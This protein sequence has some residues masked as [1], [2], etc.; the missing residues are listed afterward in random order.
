MPMRVHIDVNEFR[1]VC[2]NPLDEFPRYIIALQVGNGA[3][4]I[5]KLHPSD[6]YKLIEQLQRAVKATKLR[7]RL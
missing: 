2:P 1:V 3:D 6:I 7:E 5:A 4:V